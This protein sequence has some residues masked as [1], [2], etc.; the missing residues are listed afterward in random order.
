MRL[1]NQTRNT[2]L[3]TEVIF[4]D[5]SVKRI[6]GLLGR[7]SFPDGQALLIRPCNCIHTLFMR[8]EIDVLFLDK[9]LKIIKMLPQ[10]KPFRFSKI[11]LGA[12]MVI[13][14]PGNKLQSS[15]TNAGDILQFTD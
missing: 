3:A 7:N 6:K 4:A 2:V 1:V 15:Q 12:C 9:N 11:Y 10:L 13:E 14:L 8:F 5:T